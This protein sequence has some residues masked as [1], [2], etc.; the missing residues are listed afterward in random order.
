MRMLLQFVLLLQDKARGYELNEK[1]VGFQKLNIFIWPR[2]PGDRTNVT[3]EL[4]H[5]RSGAKE[6]AERSL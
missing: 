5:I 1:D 2:G 6:G 4:G 3:H